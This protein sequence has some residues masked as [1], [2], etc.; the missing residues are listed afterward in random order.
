LNELTA[1]H[2]REEHWYLAV[3]ATDPL[4]QGRGVGK[5]LVQPM[6]ARADE[7]GVAT[8]LETQKEASLAYYQRFGF[9]VV[10]EFKVNAS[11]PIWMMQ[12]E[13]R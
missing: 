13:P 11:P 6:A 9:E 8:Y 5:A 2:P 12:R 4:F 1:R 7:V 10:D 3:L